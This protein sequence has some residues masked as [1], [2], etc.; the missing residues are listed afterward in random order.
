[1]FKSVD[2]EDWVG[3]ML[4]RYSTSFELAFARL[5][6]SVGLASLAWLEASRTAKIKLPLL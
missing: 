2:V 1:M 3:E 5:Q 4:E 6:E